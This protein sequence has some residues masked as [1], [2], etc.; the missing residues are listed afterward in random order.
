MNT[1]T[2]HD[3]LEVSFLN[4][5]DASRHAAFVRGTEPGVVALH[6]GDGSLKGS[7][8]DVAGGIEVE[9]GALAIHLWHVVSDARY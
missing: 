8:T 7:A 4:V 2:D 1:Y 6:P 5:D 3:L 9:G